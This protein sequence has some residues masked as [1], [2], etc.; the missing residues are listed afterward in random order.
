MKFCILQVTKLSLRHVPNPHT[1]QVLHEVEVFIKDS[2][3]RRKLDLLTKYSS[4]QVKTEWVSIWE[5]MLIIFIFLAPIRTQQPEWRHRR[6]AVPAG[7][8]GQ[9][10]QQWLGLGRDQWWNGA[11]A[12]GL[13]RRHRG[14]VEILATGEGNRRTRAVFVLAHEVHQILSLFEPKV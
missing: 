7:G 13:R 14:H 10:G 12:Q 2:R 4:E 8:P 11:R 1:N 6:A 9:P 3:G 5:D